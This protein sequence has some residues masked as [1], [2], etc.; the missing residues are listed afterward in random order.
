MIIIITNNERVGATLNELFTKAAVFGGHIHIV[1][2]IWFLA[3]WGIWEYYV[4]IM[5]IKYVIGEN[6]QMENM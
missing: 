6:K 4:D 1:I 3:S 5:F 2:R